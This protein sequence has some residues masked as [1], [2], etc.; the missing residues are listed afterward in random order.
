MIK[1]HHLWICTLLLTLSS[2]AQSAQIAPA[3]VRIHWDSPHA[4]LAQPTAGG[5]RLLLSQRSERR[6]QTSPGHKPRNKK[7]R[8]SNRHPRSASSLKQAANIAQQQHGGK[9]LKVERSQSNYRVK[10][11]RDGR[12]SYV[13]VPAS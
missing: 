10:M 5:Q 11:L 2:F 13:K 3:K 9:V 4:S 8:E 1:H 12:V 6:D 7:N